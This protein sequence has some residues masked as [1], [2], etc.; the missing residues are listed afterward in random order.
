[1]ATETRSMT[2]GL[3]DARA[4]TEIRQVLRSG[5]WTLGVLAA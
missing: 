1:M 5:L 3:H 2:I 4:G